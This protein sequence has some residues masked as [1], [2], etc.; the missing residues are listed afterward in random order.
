[1]TKPVGSYPANGWGLHD[2]HGNV[3]ELCRDVSRVTSSAR[4]RT[5]PFQDPSSLDRAAR[6]GCWYEP[7]HRCL[8]TARIPVQARGRGSGLGFRAALVSTEP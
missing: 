8:S 2:M 4:T 6:G 5:D 1:M 3:W 7:G